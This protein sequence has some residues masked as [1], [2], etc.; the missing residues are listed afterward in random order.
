MRFACLGIKSAGEV[1]C[2]RRWIFELHDWRGLIFWLHIPKPL[3]TAS[4]IRNIAETDESLPFY[5]A[6][7]ALNCNTRTTYISRNVHNCCAVDQRFSYQWLPL[8][9]HI[10]NLQ[11]KN[12]LSRTI[13]IKWTLSEFCRLYNANTF[14]Y[15]TPAHIYTQTGKTCA[16]GIIRRI[17]SCVTLPVMRES[18]RHIP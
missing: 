1:L 11:H 8:Q 16:V 15:T 5:R 14:L 9:W 3:S 2:L 10:R 18:S 6:I 13:T 12:P 4:Q 17:Q 7:C